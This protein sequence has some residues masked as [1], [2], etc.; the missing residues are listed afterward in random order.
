[1]TPRH[2]L[3]LCTGN[4]ARSVLAEALLAH[5]GGARFVS[6]SAGSQPKGAVHPMA[7]ETLERHGLPTTGFRSKSWDEFGAPGAAPIDIVI[8]VCDSAANETCP[9]WPGHPSTAHW[10]IPDPAAV[11]SSPDDQRRAFEQAY[12]TLDA[13]IRLL[14]ALP[15]E[16]LDTLAVP[17]ELR[18]IATEV[19]GQ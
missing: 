10:G 19:R 14:V 1:M 11:T 2:V 5:H 3:F 6:S 17:R 13:R 4:S 7:L 8:T 16:K 9:I 12:R 15:F 18:R